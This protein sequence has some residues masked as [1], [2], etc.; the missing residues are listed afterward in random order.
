MPRRMRG[1]DKS[2]PLRLAWPLCHT[3]VR[4]G[5][6]ANPAVGLV[7]VVSH[8]CPLVSHSSP[9]RQNRSAP[10]GNRSAQTALMAAGERRTGRSAAGPRT[11]PAQQPR[12]SPRLRRSAGSR[13]HRCLVQLASMCSPS[14]S[15]RWRR[16]LQRRRA[17][18]STCPFGRL[19]H[20]VIQRIAVDAQCTDPCPTRG[21]GR[22]G[23][24][25]TPTFSRCGGEPLQQELPLMMRISNFGSD[26][27]SVNGS[28]TVAAPTQGSV[29]LTIQTSSSC[30]HYGGLG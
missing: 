29:L 22:A 1:R 9:S 20:P 11:A 16:C 21:P 28:P 3:P 8:G 13:L 30:R 4:Q 10:Q 27:N 23:L 2:E 5:E 26:R 6:P 12:C 17:I 18:S 14:W 15:R 7:G 24:A 25:E 19:A